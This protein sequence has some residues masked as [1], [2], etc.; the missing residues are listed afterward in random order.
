MAAS[1]FIGNML[2]D[3]FMRGVAPA[4][5]SQLWVALHTA[6]PGVLGEFEVT[7]LSWPGYLRQ[8]SGQG[9][10]I[11]LAWS[12]ALNKSTFNANRMDYGVMDGATQLTVTHFALWD[13]PTAGQLYFFGPLLLA[14]TLAPTDECLINPDK[15]QVTVV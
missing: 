2:L 6:D 15:L 10:T 5:P 11:D 9:D 8:D 13:A 7:A 3:C 4:L 1:T 14:K 12:A